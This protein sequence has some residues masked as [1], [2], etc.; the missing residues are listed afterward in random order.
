MSIISISGK[1]GSGKDLVGKIIQYIIAYGVSDYR[2]PISNN[3]FNDYIKHNHHLKSSWTIKKFAGKLKEVCSIITGIPIAD[4]EK[5]EV[6]NRSLGEDWIRYGYA[7]GFSHVHRDGETK[8]IMNNK[9]CSK[10]RYEEER[11]I[12]W[13]TTYKH[14]YTVREILQ[15]VGTEAIR[16][17]IHEDVWVN[18]LFNDYKERDL[19]SF[20]DPDDSNRS[21]PNW[22]I[23]D[24]R[25]PNEIEAIKKRKGIT[26]KVIRDSDKT[27]DLHP[28]EIS[29]DD[30]EFDYV[31]DN[32][33]DIDSL[34]VK[35]G[36]LL[37]KLKLIK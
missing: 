2:Y 29:L 7:D 10:E 5:E 21:L 19:R 20:G 25:F 34:M 8:T 27:I 11:R 30:Y 14:E 33:S 24:T 17:L 37:Q 13:Q 23:T 32:N 36:T 35:V 16:N 4:F 9:Q 3:D 22:I 1:K 31:L 28:S 6:K 26:I 12:N 15:L 18:A